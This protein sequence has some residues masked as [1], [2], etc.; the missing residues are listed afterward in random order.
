MDHQPSLLRR[1]RSRATRALQIASATAIAATGLAAAAAPASATGFTGPQVAPQMEQDVATVM[2]QMR[3]DQGLAPLDLI[4]TTDGS[5]NPQLVAWRNC[6][7]E[8]NMAGLLGSPASLTHDPGNVCGPKR[9]STVPGEQILAASWRS[10]GSRGANPVQTATSWLT[11]P[12]HTKWLMSPDATSMMVYAACFEAN[13]SS[14]LIIGAT[15]LNASGNW[16]TPNASAAVPSVTGDAY[17]TAYYHAC[18]KAGSTTIVQPSQPRPGTSSTPLPGTVAAARTLT[19]VL[20]ASDYSASD[21][22]TLRLYRAFFDRDP[23]AAGAAYW[24][25]QS[26]LGATPE[27]L[28]WSFANSAEFTGRY[29]QV[30]DAGFLSLMFANMLGR[31]PDPAGYAYWLDQMRS[32]GLDPHEVVRWVT[33]NTEFTNRYPFAP[34]R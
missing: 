6:L 11:S 24:I 29:G 2:N 19:D 28:A 12:P 16:S 31:S 27:T 4:V 25:S 33:A 17:N 20:A 34:I 30:D 10:G 13:G 18:P 8:L 14:Y 15:M 23:D 26:R 9:T 5:A 22:E 1:A 7:L 3:V 32:Q 21:A